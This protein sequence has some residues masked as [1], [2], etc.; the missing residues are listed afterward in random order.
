MTSRERVLAAIRRRPVDRIPTDYWGTPEMTDKLLRHL[1]VDDPFAL[2]SRLGVDKIMGVSPRYVG[3]P[4]VDAPDLRVDHWGTHRR[5][6]PYG[7]GADRGVYWE[8]SH[9]PLQRFGSVAEI[10]ARYTWPSADWFDFSDVAAAC[11]RHPEHAVMGGYMAPF[12]MFNNT[13]GLET[14]LLDMAAEPE[15]TAYCLQKVTDFLYEYHLRLFESAQ[16][17]IDVTQVTDDFG[18]QHGLLIGVGAFRRYL[19]EHYRR[20]IDLAKQFGI[21]V[22]HHDD[23]AMADLLPDLTELGID[24]LNP[25][26]WRLPGMD[27]ARLKAAYGSRIAFHGAIDNQH[28]LP[29][30]TLRDVEEE[31]RFCLATLAADGTG[32]VLAPCHNVQ[33]ITPVENVVRMYEVARAEGARS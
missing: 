15:L 23:G 28:V 32:Y 3:P 31:V 7:Q 8:M 12:Y 5:P 18:S 27:P 25:V 33:V 16:G 2:W 19:R 4:L 13:R 24:V 14:S 17:G 1:G 6:R 29:F 22:F 10:E 20:L 30:G 11:R 9:W 26:Q 21:L